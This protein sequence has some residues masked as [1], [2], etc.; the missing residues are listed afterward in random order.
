[1]GKLQIYRNENFECNTYLFDNVIL[2]EPIRFLFAFCDFIRIALGKVWLNIKRTSVQKIY[3]AYPK[4]KSKL[5][6]RTIPLAVRCCVAKCSK[7]YIHRL[8]KA[9]PAHIESNIWLEVGNSSPMLKS[10]NHFT[11]NQIEDFINILANNKSIESNVV[12]SK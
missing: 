6:L 5:H 10:R 8:A 2:N 3:C 9:C 7:I 11:S 1:M 12:A 4:C